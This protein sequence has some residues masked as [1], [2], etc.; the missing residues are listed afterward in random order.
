MPLGEGGADERPEILQH[1]GTGRKREARVPI[2][3]PEDES[4]A[5]D[6]LAWLGGGSGARSKTPQVRRVQ[7]DVATYR[8]APQLRASEDV[9]GGMERKPQARE[10]ERLSP[11]GGKRSGLAER[12]LLGHLQEPEAACAQHRPLRQRGAG[13]AGVGEKAD[14]R[15]AD[16]IDVELCP[17]DAQTMRGPLDAQGGEDGLSHIEHS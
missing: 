1:L 8:L 17:P 11:R 5:A 14:L 3:R 9:S 10:R 13:S 16:R 2:A 6:P 15:P 4:L 12:P 7:K